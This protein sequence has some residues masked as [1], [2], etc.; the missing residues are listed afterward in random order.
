MTK[1]VRISVI[2]AGSGVFSLG[3]VKDLCLNRNLRQATVSFMDIDQGR[4]EMVHRLAVRYA[5]ELGAAMRFEQTTDRERTLRDAD[6]VINTADAMGHHH[7]RDL[8]ELTARHGYYYRGIDTGS[9]H[10]F[11]L[12]LSVARDIERICPDAWLIQSGN[13][14]FDGCTLMTRQ[15]GVKVIGLC[16]GH[17]G[18]LD[19]CQVLGLDPDRVTWEAPGLNHCIWLT[20]FRYDGE[21]AY[22]RLDRWIETQGE[23]YWRTHRAERTHDKQM[24][25]GAVHLY[26]LYGLMPIGDTPR[27]GAYTTNWWYHTD[28]ATK[29]HWFGEPFGGPDT[30]IARPFYVANLEK[31][32]QQ[33]HQTAND[34]KAKV[35]EVF[36]TTPTREQQV[37]I[38]DA[39]WNNIEGRF[40][41]NRPNR[42]TVEG[43]PDDVVAEYQA[44]IDA[45]GVH[46]IKPTPL[47]RKLMIE[48][49]WPFWLE[50]E[51]NLEAYKRGDR[52]M[53]LWGVLQSHQTRGYEQ[54]TAV[55]DDVLGMPGHESMAAHYRGF[56]GRGP[57]WERQVS[58]VS[59][60]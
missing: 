39:L 44:I 38:I 14:V 8:R 53:L 15:S 18:Y 9:F 36:G 11:E 29:K 46:P 31:R 20:Q 35:T 25:R 51:H 52:S 3:L 59:G 12:M 47:P 49:V 13:P 32:L 34:P 10:N 1:P 21:D 55:L 19:L 33:I 7:A 5:D 24:S 54:A 30:E 28:L 23:E 41:V 48:Q 16:H 6:F 37:P 42:G 57:R 43:I 50:M 17:Y 4:L 60:G 56:D 40:Q 58:P 45:T 2:G 22:P 26:K 27:T